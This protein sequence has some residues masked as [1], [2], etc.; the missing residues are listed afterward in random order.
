M[1]TLAHV[2]QLAGGWIAPLIIFL[3]KRSKVLL[4]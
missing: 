4:G 1:G 3:V 2:L